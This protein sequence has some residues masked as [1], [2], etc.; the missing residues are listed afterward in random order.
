MCTFAGLEQNVVPVERQEDEASLELVDVDTRIRLERVE[1][2]DDE[3]HAHRAEP[4]LRGLL[5]SVQALLE[6][7]NGMN[8]C[9][10]VGLVAGRHLD[11]HV[12]LNVGVEECRLHVQHVQLV[13]QLHHDCEHHADALESGAN[14]LVSHGDRSNRGTSLKTPCFSRL[15]I[16]LSD[17]AFQR[18]PW[19]RSMT[20]L[21]VF[22]IRSDFP[23]PKQLGCVLVMV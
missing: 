23:P 17:V 7:H 8:S 11:E 20:S 5:E 18:Y 10:I 15:V 2:D 22:G 19:R 12:L 16:S 6:L 14:D 21:E 13:G 4:V 1:T 3:L 9:Y